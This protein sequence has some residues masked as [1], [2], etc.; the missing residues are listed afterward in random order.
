MTEDDSLDSMT[1]EERREYI[2]RVVD[3]HM[4]KHRDIYEM[5]KSLM[6]IAAYRHL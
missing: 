1:E 2:L 4:E 3:E 6:R 5:P